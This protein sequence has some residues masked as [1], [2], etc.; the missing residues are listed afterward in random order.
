MMQTLVDVAES[1]TGYA[2]V[3]LWGGP[4]VRENGNIGTWQYVRFGTVKANIVLMIVD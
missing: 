2:V 4:Q 3:V 1:E